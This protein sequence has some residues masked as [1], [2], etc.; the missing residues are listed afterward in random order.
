MIE[1]HF[2]RIDVAAAVASANTI[3]CEPSHHGRHI[4]GLATTQWAISL[5]GRFK[6]TQ[7]RFTPRRPEA[8]I[9]ENVAGNGREQALVNAAIWAVDVADN[10]RGG[11]AQ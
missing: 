6:I 2:G 11:A 1:L 8:T 10:V 7:Q 4:A 3:S 9:H 5:G